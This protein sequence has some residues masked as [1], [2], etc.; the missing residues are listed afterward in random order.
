MRGVTLVE[1]VV[2]MVVLGII[3]G[4]TVYFAYPVRQAVDLTTRAALTDI[5][6]NALQRIG[7]EVRLAL[8]NSVR[9]DISG[10]FLELIPM[11]AGGRYRVDGGGAQNGVDCPGTAGLGVP[12]S[13]QLSFDI[14]D[15]CFKTLGTVA[16]ANL[17]VVN[18]HFLVLNNYGL[19]FAN[20]DAYANGAANRVLITSLGSPPAEI[21]RNRFGFAPTTFQR[22]LHDSPGKRFYVATTPVSYACDTGARTLTRYFN[23]GFTATGL[24]PT[25]VPIGTPALIAD[26]VTFCSFNYSANVAAQIGLLTLQLTLSKAVSG[27][28]TE[29]VSLY[30]AIHVTNVP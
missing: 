21:A 11:V 23:Y 19:G 18:S 9:V 14:A 20:Q 5:A 10:N 8:P 3:V 7:R 2:A 1:L 24:Q 22:T 26:N 30:H 15:G 25:V 4:T 12:A 28:R 6:D 29:T 17:I 13:D 27:G 16:N